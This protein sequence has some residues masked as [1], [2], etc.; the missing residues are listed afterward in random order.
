M[1]EEEELKAEYTF[2]QEELYSI[3]RTMCASAKEDIDALHDNLSEE[4]DIPHIEAIEAKV[5]AAEALPDE[6]QRSSPHETAKVI[7]EEENET[8]LA[9]FGKLER[10]IE[11]SFPKNQWKIKTDEAGGTKYRKASNKNWEFTKAMLKDMNDFVNNAEYQAILE[12]DNK[13]PHAFVAAVGTAK[14][15]FNTKYESFKTKRQTSDDTQE[16]LTA[17]NEVNRLLQ[18][19]SKDGKVALKGNEGKVNRYIIEKVKDLVSPPGSASLFLELQNS[20]FEPVV[21]AVIKIQAEGKAAIVQVTA[22]DPEFRGGR[23]IANFD[24]VD[25]APYTVFVYAKEGDKTPLVTKKKDVNK[26]TD[27]RLKIVLPE[28][29]TGIPFPIP[30]TI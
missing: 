27:A 7:L 16:K 19:L 26:G 18:E 4:Y 12:T 24:G 23:A 30:P 13:M 17:N 25:P 14:T 15:N 10:Y 5:D 11:K 9:T 2:T 29:P 3:T 8:S 20:A 22:L 6:D 1:P 21:G 28:V